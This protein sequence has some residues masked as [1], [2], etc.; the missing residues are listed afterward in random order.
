M[1]DYRDNKDIKLATGPKKK[2]VMAPDEN[3]FY[4]VP[5]KPST[6]IHGIIS[7]FYGETSSKEIEDKYNM[8]ADMVSEWG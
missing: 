3:A 5:N 4:G 2:L 8:A 1:K 7:N 6:P